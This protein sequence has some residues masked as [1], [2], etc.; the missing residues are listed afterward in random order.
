MAH[1]V[2]GEP[3]ATADEVH[4]H[5]FRLEG[6]EFFDRRVE[7]DGDEF[8]EGFDLGGFID[9]EIQVGHLMLKVEHFGQDGIEFVSAH[10]GGVVGF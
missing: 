9:R 5:H 4:R 7:F 2:F 1:Q 6:G 8:T 10:G 3:A